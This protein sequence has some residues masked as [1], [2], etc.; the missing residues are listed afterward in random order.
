M[1]NRSG[2]AVKSLPKLI[3]LTGGTGFLGSHIAE[4][5]LN[6][7]HN[8]RIA[9]RTTSDL[10]WLAFHPYEIVV[11][12]LSNQQECEDFLRGASDVI[13]C[14]GVVSGPDEATYRRGNVETTERLLKAAQVVWQDES[15]HTF[16]FISSLAAH[17]PATLANPATE[18]SPCHP[19]TAYGRSKLAAEE[20]VTAAAGAFRRIILRPP[21][22]Y[23]PR[24][25]EFLPLLKTARKGWTARLGRKISGLSLVDGRDAAAAMIALL[26]T[27]EAQGIYFVADQQGG[28]DWDQI[29]QALAKAVRRKVRRITIPLVWLKLAA[30]INEW[31]GSPL[32]I[33]SPDRFLDLNSPGWV[34]DGSR[35]TRDTGYVAARDAATGFA[36]T[37]R[38]YRGQG[39]L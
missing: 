30:R 12:D 31:L 5:L 32:L 4:A 16:A 35:L 36:E 33:L 38:F 29:Q 22:L 17:G 23:G 14:A 25:R 18:D 39:W 7:G 24:D 2:E 28:Y 6:E 37:I 26:R 27:P 10:Q 11:V 19:I 13:H 15:D 1:K 34:C 20:R 9:V 8:V 21:S 3:A